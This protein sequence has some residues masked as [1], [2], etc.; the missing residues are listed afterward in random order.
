M[1]SASFPP[2]LAALALLAGAAVHADVL[3][4]N[5]DQPLRY[6]APLHADFW[7]AQS[8]IT[9]GGD[10][11]VLDAVTLRLGGLIRRCWPS[12]A[13]TPPMRPVRLCCRSR[14]RRWRPAPRPTCRS[15][16]RGR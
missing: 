15:W 9:P 3:V 16:P 12:C 4:D 8:F 1:T 10:P 11:L 7:Y 14:C 13:P 6:P 5:L 2:G